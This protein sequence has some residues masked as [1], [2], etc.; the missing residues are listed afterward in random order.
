MANPYL[1][2]IRLMSFG[3]APKGWA[4]CNG[5]IMSIQQNTALF[6]LLGTTYGGNGTSNFA[7]P[8]LQSQAPIHF[9]QGPGLSSYVQGETSGFDAIT[10]NS[11]MNPLH[12]HALT[13]T[14]ASA[15]AAA[16]SNT[17]LPAA[18]TVTGASF[19]AVVQ[20]GP[21]L[22]PQTMMAATITSTGGQPHNN[23]MPSLA[24]TFAIALVGIFPS[25][26]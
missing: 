3:F 22:Q 7:L 18:P 25:R 1:G 12:S 13:V 11:S 26:N 2:E 24:I 9:G 8:N 21:A 5:Q 10:L 23:M 16:I 17:V 4:L 19:Y 14:T 6:S 20:S 15:T